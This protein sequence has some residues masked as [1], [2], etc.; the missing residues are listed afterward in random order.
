MTPSICEVLNKHDGA[1]SGQQHSSTVRVPCGVCHCATQTVDR[2]GNAE[3]STARC[4]ATGLRTTAAAHS[5]LT[6]QEEQV[7]MMN[8]SPN[9]RK[10][11]HH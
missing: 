6:N 3:G 10:T 8:R 5:Q 4:R 9:R 7:K 11:M 2:F 1:H